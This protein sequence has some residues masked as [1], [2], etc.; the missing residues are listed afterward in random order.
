MNPMKNLE[1][2]K[3]TLNIGSGKSQDRL[4]KG[5]KLLK[6][7]T[8]VPPVKTITK[9]RIPGWALRPGLPIGAKIT[10]RKGKASELI[11]ALL[12]AKDSVLSNSN[13]DAEGNVSFG[14]HEY[15][16]VPTVKY[17]P[18]IGIMGFQV[19][20]TIKRKGFRIKNRKEKRRSIPKRHRVTKEESKKFMESSF[21]VK[22]KEEE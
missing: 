17:D 13:F 5:V 2:E 7:I 16:D 12:K 14:I 8:G 1:V 21:G 11:A 18:E 6:I 22:I 10:I 9:K 15:I 19:C 20:I 4:E 3:L